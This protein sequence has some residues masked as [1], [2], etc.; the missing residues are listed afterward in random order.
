MNL[1]HITDSLAALFAEHRL[2]FWYDPDAAFLDLIPE[3][4]LPKVTVLRLDQHPALA[5][6]VR[7]ELE[8]RQGKYLLYAPT[9]APDPAD[10]W[11]LDIRLYSRVFA[12][13][14]ASL[15]LDE[16]GLQTQF[17]RSHIAAREAFF[18]SKERTDKLKRFV[19]PG[20]NEDAL[21]LKMLAVLVRAEQPELFP[22]L[23]R[24][25]A[26]SCD[27]DGFDPRV[28]PRGWQDIEKMGLAPAFWALIA[29]AFGYN[30][31][32][33]TLYGLLIRLFA[34]EFSVKCKA[35]SP[36]AWRN[37]LL[38][39]EPR[40]RVNCAVLLDQWRN[41]LGLYTAYDALSAFFAAELR[42]AE[43]LTG[44]ALDALL[45]VMTFETVE[46][47]IIVLLRDEILSLQSVNGGALGEAIQRR[48]DGHW[49]N[50]HFGATP[51][52]ALFNDIY[53]ALQRAL[54]LFQQRWRHD[55]GLSFASAK[56]MANA[57]ANELFRFDQLYRQFHHAADKVERGGEDLLKAL[58]ARVESCYVG[59]FLEQLALC[60]DGFLDQGAGEGLLGSWTLDGIRNQYDFYPLFV[61]SHLSANPRNKVFVIVSDALRFEA[62][63]E[64]ARSINGRYRFQAELRPLLGVAPSFT[65]LGMA[66]LLPHRELRF[67]P[68]NAEVL[69]D[70]LP[71]NGLENRN[72]ILKK[73]NG[74]ALKAEDVI[75]MSKEE[76]R[77]RV[78]DFRVVYIYHDRIDA[79]GDKAATEGHTFE[80]VHEA[81]EELAALVRV[82]VNTLNGGY[83]LVTADHGFVFQNTTPDRLDK[84]ALE[85]PPGARVA[86]KRYILGENLGRSDKVFHGKTEITASAK[87]DL[88]FWSPRGY[89]RFHFVGGARFVHGG[90]SL[91]EIMIPILI[92]RE[93]RGKNLEK[94]Q[95]RKVG[96]CLLGTRRKVVT[97]LHRFEF[98][99]TEPVSE[100]VKPVTLRISLRD[101]N[102]LVSDEARVTFESASSSLD[103]RKTIVTLTLKGMTYDP[104]KAYSLVLRDAENDTEC[105]RI[106]F[107]VDLAFARDF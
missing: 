8:D 35:A 23:M 107:Y 104:R 69:V 78:R 97:S 52:S 3:L 16:L 100:R 87:D 49:A 102:E 105:E 91:Q 21:D 61:Q 27:Q 85:A 45:E 96:V 50:R 29:E 58:A 24:L 77:A 64:L 82:V 19:A 46:R 89:G 74:V 40:R 99:Q 71:A 88:E 7:L 63:E 34:T 33:P 94:S 36:L 32:A 57:Y 80:A 48:R 72:A 93:A 54:E 37:F 98:I 42:A 6:K 26:V 20:D 14:S 103:E 15:I 41:H 53:D 59:W 66:A 31:A 51:R 9:P 25:F 4:D 12:A 86:H 28:A 83:V 60:W 44:Y 39:P 2:V 67:K 101:G 62:A 65:A 47:M 22:V 13:D 84:H 11:L 1:A 76:G 56:D 73:V 38:D 79:V 18:R 70:G 55:R 43:A 10:D 106:A 75:A 17:L 30:D 90:L 92:I 5:L 81:I 68:A 95:T